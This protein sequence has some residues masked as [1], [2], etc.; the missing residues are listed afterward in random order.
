MKI[1]D[2]TKVE[3]H[4]TVYVGKL[5]KDEFKEMVLE[6][7]RKSVGLDRFDI[8]LTMTIEVVGDL[9]NP[10]LKYHLTHDHNYYRKLHGPE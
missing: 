3:T 6:V 2:V 9:L 7:V 5:D 1:A 8:G 4:E 10:E